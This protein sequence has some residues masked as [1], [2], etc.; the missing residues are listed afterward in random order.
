MVR[1][2]A[3]IRNVHAM[4]DGYPV[5]LD[6]EYPDRELNRLTTFLRAFTIIPIAIV[7]ATVSGGEAWSWSDN[8]GASDATTTVV[9]GAGGM[10]VRRPG[11]DDGVPARSTPAGGS[12]GTSS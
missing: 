8:G 12:T 10:L 7:L 2:A 4:T 6:V 1:V 5:Q 9:V 11:A 3:P